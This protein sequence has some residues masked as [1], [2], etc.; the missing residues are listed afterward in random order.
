MFQ[1]PTEN[2]TAP[3]CPYCQASHPEP[4]DLDES[5]AHCVACDDC[6]K[7]YWAVCDYQGWTTQ[8]G[9]GHNWHRMNGVRVCSRCG[10]DG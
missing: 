2:T 3:V 6:G 9:G 8:C 10:A 1:Y 4:E 7:L 5:G